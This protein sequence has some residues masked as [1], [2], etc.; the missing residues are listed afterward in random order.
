[1]DQ[2]EEE[3]VSVTLEPNGSAQIARNL[4][5]SDQVLQHYPN[6]VQSV[7]TPTCLKVVFPLAW[8][9]CSDGM[10]LTRKWQKPG[11]LTVVLSEFS[12]PSKD[13]AFLRH[14]CCFLPPAPSAATPVCTLPNHMALASEAVFG[15]NTPRCSARSPEG[16][17]AHCICFNWTEL[18]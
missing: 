2:C 12:C 13:T 4:E 16:C 1:M 18:L 15:R 10:L 7:K 3:A 8:W 5:I 14:T 9:S 17:C 6:T 11:L